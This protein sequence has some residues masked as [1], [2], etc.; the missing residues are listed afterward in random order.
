MSISQASTL[1][2]KFLKKISCFRRL[3][4]KYDYNTNTPTNI[5]IT[6]RRPRY[7]SPTILWRILLQLVL[8]CS[9]RLS[10]LHTF[11]T[12]VLLTACFTNALSKQNVRALGFSVFFHFYR[13]IHLYTG[14]MNVCIWGKS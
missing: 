5:N 10:L 4:E 9:L 3:T 8:F 1:N 12:V 7:K 14:H 6:Q 11:L 2:N 13:Y